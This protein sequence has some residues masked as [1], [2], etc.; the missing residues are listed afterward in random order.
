MDIEVKDA[1]AYVH[2]PYNYD[3]VQGMRSVNRARWNEREKAWVAPEIFIPQIRKIMFA[4]YGETD[5]EP[6]EDKR[7]ILLRFLQTVYEQN[8]PVTIYGKTVARAFGRDSGAKVGTDVAF[9]VGSPTSGG[10]NKYWMTIIPEGCE[11][12]L[13][14]VPAVML[15]QKLPDGVVAVE[16][17]AV[18]S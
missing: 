7:T 18:A 13:H 5:A 16:Q 10:S 2:T 4:A 15:A 14:N 12:V 17:A 3:F 8:K 6:A 1:S 9:S 11:V